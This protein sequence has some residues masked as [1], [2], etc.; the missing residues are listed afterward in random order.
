MTALPDLAV[1]GAGPAGRALAHRAV[2]AGL[3]VVIV[4][5]APD[6]VWSATYGLYTADLPGWFD[7]AVIA[8]SAPSVTVFT[9]DERV[10]PHGYAVL[11]TPALQRSLTV[12]GARVVVDSA[13]ALTA[14]T[15]TRSDGALIRA[16]HVV[17][18]RGA[19]TAE[20]RD[21]PRQ[22]AAGAVIDSPDPTMV[23]MDWRRAPDRSAERAP[24]FSYRV[25]L[26]DGR[27]LVEE[28]C[29]AGAPPVD[30]DELAARNLARGGSA[31]VDEAVDFPLLTGAAPWRRGHD[32]AL[33]VGAAGGLMNP[34]TGYSVGQSLTVAD[35]VAAAIAAGRDP[36]AAVWPRSAR[37]AFGLRATGLGVLLRLDPDDLVCF[38]DAFFRIDPTLQRRYLTAHADAHGV[39]RAMGSVF[40]RLPMRL[41]ATVAAATVY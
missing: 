7:P 1:V 16:R 39:V 35:T 36:H 19:R 12:D 32:E 23:L 31:D 41:R 3:R 25:A 30:V 20:H 14:T 37:T 13:V 11:D 33:R 5:P 4:D 38:F 27:R 26:G 29:L 28:T 2:A 8:A 40:A 24:S 21:R 15:V 22:T 18:A 17:D 9:P 10:L 6:R 34:A